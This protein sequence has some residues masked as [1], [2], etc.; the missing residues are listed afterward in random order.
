MAKADFAKAKKQYPSSAMGEKEWYAVFDAYP[1]I[2]WAILADV[3]NVILDE[4]ERDEGIHRIGRR[5]ARRAN[6]M[7]ELR[8]AVMPPQFNTEPFPVALKDLMG[9]RSQRQFAPRIPID[10]PTLSRFLSGQLSPDLQMLEAIAAACKV[11]AH[12]FVEYRALFISEMVC[13]VLTARPN[14]GVTAFKAYRAS[15]NE[16]SLDV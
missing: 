5:P 2:M 11:P 1:D 4:R 10:Q 16:R 8:R 15:A 13:R 9:A 7:E 12:Y 14:L 6:S 3:Y